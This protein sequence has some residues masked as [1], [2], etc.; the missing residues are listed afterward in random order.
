M[1]KHK[2][3]QMQKTITIKKEFNSLDR[4]NNFLKETTEFECSK[5]YDTWEHRTDTNGQ[6]AQ[7]L[8]L[9]KSNM[10]AVKAY[11]TDTNTLKIDHV[12]PNKFMQAYFGKSQKARKNML[13]IIAEGIKK[14]LLTAPKQ[15]AFNEIGQVFGTITVN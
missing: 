7:C 3:Y 6:L 2:Q 5:E 1:T 9:K 15:K 4:L 13:D 8:V 11:F 12:I 14:A 10:H